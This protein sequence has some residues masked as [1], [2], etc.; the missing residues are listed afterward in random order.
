MSKGIEIGVGVD[1]SAAEKGIKAGLIE[2]L[3]D[4]QGEL[5]K[6]GKG[7]GLDELEHDLGEAAKATDKLKDETKRDAEQIA[8]AYRD[9]ARAAQ[10]STEE[11]RSRGREAI[12]EVKNEALQ[13]ASQVFSSFD[14]S[15]QG[16]VDGI[17][18]TFGGLVASIGPLLGPAGLLGAVAGAAGIGLIT[19]ALGQADERTKAVVARASELIDIYKETGEV[20]KT[21]IQAVV[22]QIEELAK[23][24][25]GA[26]DSWKE[27]NE[28]FAKAGL[29][30]SKYAAQWA[31][32]T[33][34][35]V[36]AQQEL[37]AALQAQ[38]DFISRKMDTTTDT[39]AYLDLTDQLL[40]VNDLKGAL[41]D[42]GQ[43]AAEAGDA[44]KASAQA[45]LPELQVKA[46]LV[47]QVN[48]AYDDLAGS[49][50]DYI[51]AESGLFDVAKYIA[52]MEAREQALKDYQKSLATSGL[53]NEAKDFLTQ[54][55]EAAAAAMLAGYMA[56][57][58]GQKARLAQVWEEAAK[59]DSG[60][61]TSAAAAALSRTTIPGP[62]I[63]LQAP[64]AGPV[65]TALQQGL[66]KQK[67]TVTADI[68]D[69][70][71]RK[72]L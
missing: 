20:G 61:Y 31:A 28:T 27:L 55:G 57:S 60:V 2:P 52:A 21:S 54:Q 18:G 24:G 43:A 59:E 40:A 47:D 25:E 32:A 45:G 38:V 58:P 39:D 44:M 4:A 49:A 19:S 17:Q 37:L 56:A 62:A 13:N 68:V 12:G 64:D 8:Q 11:T 15:T 1:G 22:D 70:Y 51:D 33:A 29:N 16:F 46:T 35:N 26:N 72:I 69:R 63:L 71:G 14:G 50:E 65:M 30:G 48:T 7:K 42:E 66:S 23:G 67:L 10:Q 5:E 53:S 36:D 9:Q 34:G 3:E 41:Q 6:L